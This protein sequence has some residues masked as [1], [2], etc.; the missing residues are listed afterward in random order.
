MLPHPLRD[1]RDNAMAGKVNAYSNTSTL[2]IITNLPYRITVLSFTWRN[3]CQRMCTVAC[4]STRR[5]TIAFAAL[6]V[7]K[8]GGYFVG[9]KNALFPC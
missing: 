9:M 5:V 2:H 8:N 3:A 7:S 4:R 1:G 6:T